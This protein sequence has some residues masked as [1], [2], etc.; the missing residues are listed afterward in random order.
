MTDSAPDLPRSIDNLLQARLTDTLLKELQ[1]LYPDLLAEHRA[2]L[3]A[4]AKDAE[5]RRRL[6][7]SVN[8]AIRAAKDEVK[9][10][11]SSIT[12]DDEL[13][14]RI[15]LLEDLA[16]DLREEL[17]EIREDAEFTT[18]ERYRTMKRIEAWSQPWSVELRAQ[19]EFKEVL[20]GMH[21]ETQRPMITGWVGDEETLERLEAFLATTKPPE[22]LMIKVRVGEPPA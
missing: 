1:T 21:G 13:P 4:D 16:E 14:E 6:S 20:I 8:A 22:D 7:R 5:S 19:P 12:D 17:H 2:V 18:T 10:A 3:E 11:R 9:S 15:E